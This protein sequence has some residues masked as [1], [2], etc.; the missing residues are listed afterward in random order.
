MPGECSIAVGMVGVVNGWVS[1]FFLWGLDIFLIFRSFL[2]SEVISRSA[3][4]EATL[5][6]HAYK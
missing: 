5:I 2:R 6:C 4:R 3:A 1:K